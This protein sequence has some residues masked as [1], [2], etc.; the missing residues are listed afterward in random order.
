[1]SA[2]FIIL[3][4]V[5]GA[6]IGWLANQIMVQGN[7]GMQTDLLVGVGGAV[8]GGWL[9]FSVL[10]LL[11]GQQA[12]MLGHIVNAALGAVIATFVGRR[13]IKPQ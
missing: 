8:V 5:V 9:L 10:G 6:V 13:V 1:M 4:A 12:I 7:L 2:E 11:G 3:W